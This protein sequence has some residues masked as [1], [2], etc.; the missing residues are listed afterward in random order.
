MEVQISKKKS[1]INIEQQLIREVFPTPKSQYLSNIFLSSFCREQKLNAV[2]KPYVDRKALVG[3]EVETEN[4]QFI[5]PNL[6]IGFWEIT[7]DGSLR[8]N[9]REFKTRGAIPVAFTERALTH[10]FSNLNSSIDF[11]IRTSIH[12]HQ[13]VRGMS[14]EQVINLLLIYITVE[15]LLFKFAGANRRNSIYCVPILDTNFLSNMQS[16]EK[17]VATLSHINGNWTKYTAL[18]LLPIAQFGSIEYRHMPGTAD[19]RKLVVWIDLLS[20]I[21]V[22]AYQ[23]SYSALV[24]SIVKLNTTSG[25]L[26]Y[27]HDIFGELVNYLDTTLLLSDMEKNVYYIKNCTLTNEFHRHVVSTIVPESAFGKLFQTFRKEIG[28]AKWKIL[29][30]IKAQIAPNTDTEELYAAMRRRPNSYKEAYPTMAD[31]I[32]LL[33][34]A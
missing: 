8:N 32:S 27:L 15:N 17:M 3:I 12:V 11:S 23:T 9:G 28:D 6:S 14:L 10:L 33:C 29:M 13:D 22:H 26:A 21:K 1:P 5:G 25:Y 34:A 4:V 20:A 7:E 30:E 31:K 16:K 18:N 19:I 2:Y 24:D